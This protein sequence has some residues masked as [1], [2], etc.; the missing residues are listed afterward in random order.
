MADEV[1]RLR[2][3]YASLLEP[4]GVG[5]GAE[6]RA[7][8][9][10]RVH[11]DEMPDVVKAKLR[12]VLARAPEAR[13]IGLYVEQAF[14]GIATLASLAGTDGTAGGVLGEGDGSAY[15]L[16]SAA[17]RAVEFVCP[18]CGRREYAPFYDTRRI[19]QCHHRAMKLVEA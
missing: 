18:N 12:A 16:G 9:V 13:R 2:A 6:A 19:P 14:V 3:P 15:P 11:P 17:F 4:D 8:Q 7:D 1:D 5:E 10:L